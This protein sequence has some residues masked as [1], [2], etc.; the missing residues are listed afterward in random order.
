[1]CEPSVNLLLNLKTIHVGAASNEEGVH[2]S[3]ATIMVTK[4]SDSLHWLGCLL[5]RFSPTFVL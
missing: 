2:L 5:Y 4:H 1:M 3:T